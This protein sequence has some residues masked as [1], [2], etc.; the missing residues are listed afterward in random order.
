M[1]YGMQ[2]GVYLMLDEMTYKY[3][4]LIGQY[5]PCILVGPTALWR[6]GLTTN[7]TSTLDVSTLYVEL[8]GVGT[9]AARYYFSP[10]ADKFFEVS[11]SPVHPNIKQPTKERALVEYMLLHEYFDEGLLIEGIKSYL[12]QFDY[13]VT[14]LHDVMKLFKVKLDDLID[15]WVNE[16]LT[17]YEV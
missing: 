14:R 15:Y 7:V 5:G 13:D 10:W 11:D 17:D 3:D 2:R 1:K 8:R 16:A 4:K 12:F 9:F 6:A